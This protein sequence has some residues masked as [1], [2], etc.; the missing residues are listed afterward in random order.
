[1]TG[2]VALAT[3]LAASGVFT[4]SSILGRRSDTGPVE[5]VPRPLHAGSCSE[6]NLFNQCWRPNL[7]RKDSSYSTEIEMANVLSN[8]TMLEELAVD[9]QKTSDCVHTEMANPNCRGAYMG[10]PDE[11]GILHLTAD[12]LNSSHHLD[13]VQAAAGTPCLSSQDIYEAAYMDLS[14]CYHHFLAQAQNVHHVCQAIEVLRTCSENVVSTRCGAPAADFT[15]NVWDFMEDPEVYDT[16][17]SVMRMPELSG[18]VGSCQ[19]QARLVGGLVK[20]A[21][22]Q[23]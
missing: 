10:D 19:Q 5:P 18:P 7:L 23:S 12:Y 4:E 2:L 22:N 16:I 9:Y 21:L 6:R 13:I 8:R 3:L 20:R 14:T 17:L 15:Q 1:M 11:V